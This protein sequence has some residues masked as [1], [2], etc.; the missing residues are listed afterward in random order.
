MPLFQYA[1]GSYGHS[2]DPYFQPGLLPLLDRGIVYAI[3]HVRRAG[4]GAA[5]V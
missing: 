5:M 1:Y 2:S 3:A 4:D